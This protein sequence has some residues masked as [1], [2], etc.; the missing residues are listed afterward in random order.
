MIINTPI[1]LGELVDKISILKIKKEKIKNIKKLEYV[2]KEMCELEQILSNTKID[3]VK[4]N[5]F[6]NKLQKINLKLWD[7]E[8]RIRK[9]ER[10]KSFDQFF[11]DLARSVY[12]FNDE[13]SQIKL[14]INN[15][16]GSSI[17]EVKSYEKY[18]D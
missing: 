16:F 8:N 14:T 15:E 7:I 13:R 3:T 12:K 17:V 2:N 18:S 6:L 9:C 11:I 1:S 10:L 4:I 5:Q